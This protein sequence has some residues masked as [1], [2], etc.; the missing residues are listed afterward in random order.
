MFRFLLLASLLAP[1]PIRAQDAPEGVLQAGVVDGWATPSGTRIAAVKIALAE[2]WKTYWRAPGDAGIPPLF[3]FAA[4][5]NVASVRIVWPSPEVFES[6]GQRTVGYLGALVLPLE[7]TP[8]DPSQPI[9]LAAE[10][11]MGICHDVCVPVSMDL[12]AD[13]SGAGAPE[14]Q[15]NAAMTATPKPR[16]GIARCSAEPIAD[17]MRLT[18][19]IDAPQAE[20]ALFE[21]TDRPIWVSQT[22]IRREGAE[23]IAEVDMVPPEAKPFDIQGDALR[24][25]VLGG[26]EALEIAGCSIAPL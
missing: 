5:T 14:A 19:R 6:A 2:G 10:V 3:N 16:S 20:M 7:I 17:G 15:I 1:L 18:A 23:L 13:L 8:K 4:S 22:L 25:T 24:I 21:L 11:D 26:P 12:R 9:Q